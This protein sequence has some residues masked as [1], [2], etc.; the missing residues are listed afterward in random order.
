MSKSHLQVAME[1]LANVFQKSV[2]LEALGVIKSPLNAFSD[3]KSREKTANEMDSVSKKSLTL[4]DSGNVIRRMI[5]DISE[6]AYFTKDYLNGPASNEIANVDGS[7]DGTGTMT[8]LRILFTPSVTADAGR[9]KYFLADDD[10]NVMVRNAEDVAAHINVTPD[11]PDR[12]ASPTIAAFLVPH[13]QTNF[14]STGTD[15]V[16][17]FANSIPSIELSRCV[18][19]V[20]LNFISLLAKDDANESPFGLT[21]FLGM[22]T[23]ETDHIGLGFGSMATSSGDDAAG[24]MAGISALDPLQSSASE[25]VLPSGAVV[26]GMELFTS[27]QTLINAH[28][29]GV[30]PMGSGDFG[31]MNVVDKFR[32][33]MSLENLRISVF[34][35]D[36]GGLADLKANAK[37][38]VHDRARLYELG[39]LVDIG[40]S[41][42][43]L[44]DLTYGWAHPDGGL[45][46][47]N[48]YGKFLNALKTTVTLRLIAPNISLRDDGQI[49]LDLEMQMR[50]DAATKDL[51]STAGSQIPSSTATKIIERF[52]GDA[53]D[54]NTS[55]TKRDRKRSLSV[56]MKKKGKV[57]N[58][59]SPAGTISREVWSSTVSAQKMPT[60]GTP[61]TATAETFSQ[62]KTI[63]TQNLDPDAVKDSIKTSQ[64]IFSAKVTALQPSSDNDVFFK[65]APG[66]FTELSGKTSK[67][68]LSL[69]KF[70]TSFLAYPA[71]SI[72]S[73]DEIQI[74]FYPIN[75]YAGRMAGKLTCFMPLPFELL[76]GRLEKLYK[77]NPELG[78]K[79]MVGVVIKE[80]INTPYAP[81]WGLSNKYDLLEPSTDD[82]DAAQAA[83]MEVTSEIKS[84]LKELYA[85]R[86]SKELKF[87]LPAIQIF[88]ET[89]PAKTLNTTKDVNLKVG[90][91]L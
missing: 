25:S 70:I 33:L 4:S 88:M 41:A 62:L 87:Q 74:F 49:S 51:P 17:L 69:G 61:P 66:L 75:E 80:L 72:G 22:N 54:S 9:R 83:N 68:H 3:A 47:S 76:K 56:F 78:C 82:A 46:S 7:D 28:A 64:G 73:A 55:N 84:K 85:D 1:E 39:P 44:V 60:D 11:A 53:A 19:Y 30:D 31:D 90:S 71:A 48:P 36:E 86:L 77:D 24:G 59:G 12:Y 79:S 6:G 63:L 43:T 57:K 37:I 15:V 10:I 38:M 35:A 5:S 34:G 21:R 91:G 32:P 52:A 20:R 50:A 13:A 42:Y 14:A 67:A 45:E 89:L 65:Y 26:T 18:P 16:E 27:P 2:P 81:A 23:R 8:Y 40:A 58:E 29:G